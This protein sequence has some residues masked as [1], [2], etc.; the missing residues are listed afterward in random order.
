MFD[1]IYVDW[2]DLPKDFVHCLANN[3]L[4]EFYYNSD[5]L[6]KTNRKFE[7]IEI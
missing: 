2:S 7:E 5:N 6:R 4:S 3:I 1:V